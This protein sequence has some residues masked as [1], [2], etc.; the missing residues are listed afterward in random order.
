MYTMTPD[1]HFLV[2]RHPEFENVC[3]AAGLSGHGFKFAPVLAR[4]LADLALDGKTNV[5]IDFLRLARIR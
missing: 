3:F 2:D 1:D 4:A 5:P